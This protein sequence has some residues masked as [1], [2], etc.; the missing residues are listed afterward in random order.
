M[1]A[2]DLSKIDNAFQA[3]SPAGKASFGRLFVFEI[4]IKTPNREGLRPGSSLFFA[5]AW[6]PGSSI[7]DE[8]SSGQQ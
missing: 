6:H 4:K 5:A 2:A 3:E 1:R 8:C 7:K